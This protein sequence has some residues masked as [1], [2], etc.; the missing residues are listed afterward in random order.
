MRAIRVILAI[1]A[2]VSVVL[3][4]LGV[5]GSDMMA[6]YSGIF[7]ILLNMPGVWVLKWFGMSTTLDASGF[8]FGG[9]M[10]LATTQAVLW[11]MFHLPILVRRRLAPDNTIER[12]AGNSGT[13]PTL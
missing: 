9:L 12:D 4:T 7:F 6:Y 2:A 1:Q 13:R 8:G 10:L 11:A 3:W 5:L